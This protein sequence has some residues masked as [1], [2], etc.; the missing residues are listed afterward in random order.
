[1]RGVNPFLYM[2]ILILFFALNTAADGPPRIEPEF[3]SLSLLL[4]FVY[5][6]A[7]MLLAAIISENGNFVGYVL[8]IGTFLVSLFLLFFLELISDYLWFLSLV[9]GLSTLLG[10]SI[11]KRIKEKIRGSWKRYYLIP[12]LIVLIIASQFVISTTSVYVHNSIY[13]RLSGWDKI[14][15]LISTI[16][17]DGSSGTFT[18]LFLNV[19]GTTV[20][21]SSIQANESYSNATCT[22]VLVDESLIPTT[23]YPVRPGDGFKLAATGCPRLNRGDMYLMNITINYNSVVGGINTTNTETGTIRTNAE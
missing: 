23:G 18:V 3:T 8:L 9:S 12:L 1:M 20:K 6:F 5:F 22:T 4:W 21:L 15:P 16:N 13:P 14:S 11:P 17:Y 2:P 10:I 19:K 7:V